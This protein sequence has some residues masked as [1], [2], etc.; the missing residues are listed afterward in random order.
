[1]IKYRK[2]TLIELVERAGCGGYTVQNEGQPGDRWTIPQD[3][4]ETT[5]EQAYPTSVEEL[6]ASGRSFDFGY[7]LTLLKNGFRVARA[8]WNGKGMFAVYQKGYPD[9]IPC[10]KQTADAW[11]MQEGELFKVEPYLQLKMANGSHA[12]WNP[13][14]LDILAEDWIV[15]AEAE[16]PELAHAGHH[17]VK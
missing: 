13:N 14:T 2:K 11:G 9:G 16:A 7:A 10:N 3:V 17:V 1:M 5:Y 4:F 12:M 8:G 6:A 15:L